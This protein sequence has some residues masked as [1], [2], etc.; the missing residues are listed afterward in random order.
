VKL[1][2]ILEISLTKYFTMNTVEMNEEVKSFFLKELKTI[3]V[4]KH[5]NVS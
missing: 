2:T 3:S 1:K 5:L 4:S